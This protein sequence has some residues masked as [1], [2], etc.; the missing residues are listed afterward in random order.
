MSPRGRRHYAAAIACLALGAATPRE[1]ALGDVSDLIAALADPATRPDAACDLVRRR[2]EAGR[3]VP[4]LIDALEDEVRRTHDGWHA[5]SC[6][7]PITE[8][9]RERMRRLRPEQRAAYVLR[10]APWVAWRDRHPIDVPVATALRA[11]GGAELAVL[12]V[13]E[14]VRAEPSL[15]FDRRT[16]AHILADLGPEAA[17]ALLR[18]LRDPNA[19]VRY[20]AI[21]TL[22]RIEP[23][24]KEV[25]PALERVVERDGDLRKEAAQALDA[26]RSRAPQPATSPS[27]KASLASP[28]PKPKPTPAPTPLATPTSAR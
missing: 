12:A 19:L 22:P 7:A 5:A 18:A 27:P 14:M 6:Y 24:P 20:L 3:A 4:A 8:K 10:H 15:R 17:P 25:A 26:I 13:L 21:L 1:S 9:D 28:T 11:I 23:L 16:C 2:N